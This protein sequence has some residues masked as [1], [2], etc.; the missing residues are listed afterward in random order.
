MP[1]PSSLSPNIP[2]A[3]FIY[4]F[5]IGFCNFGTIKILL[6]IILL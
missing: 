5:L 3:S 6:P 4:E 1:K 2:I